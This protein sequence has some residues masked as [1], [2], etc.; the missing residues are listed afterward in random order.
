M[1]FEETFSAAQMRKGES[2]AETP[3]YA[4]PEKV[5]RMSL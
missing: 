4:K 2:D 5:Q 3:Q 1:P